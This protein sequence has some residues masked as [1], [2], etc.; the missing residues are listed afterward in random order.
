MSLA[1]E[2]RSQISMNDIFKAIP[3]LKNDISMSIRGMGEYSIICG[4]HIDRIKSSAIPLKYKSVF[5][6]WARNEGFVVRNSYNGYGVMYID[7][8][9]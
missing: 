4:S 7:L 9:L 1:D 5:E 6:N 2:L 3:N 8:T